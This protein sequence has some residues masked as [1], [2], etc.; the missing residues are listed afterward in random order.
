MSERFKKIYAPNLVALLIDT[1]TERDI[2]GRVLH[3]YEEEAI[4]F[5]GASDLVIRLDAL[6]DAWS[7]PQR[8]TSQRYFKDSDKEPLKAATTHLATRD[9]ARTMDE[10]YEARG[11]M[12]TFMLFVEYRQNASW[13]G[14]IIR[15]EDGCTKSFQSVL[16]LMRTVDKSL[17]AA[18]EEAQ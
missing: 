4:P 2:S 5:A 11:E 1:R 3:L 7:Y 16:E 9:K 18:G 13:Q 10:L 15:L 12:A 17:G 8:A 6:Y 14:Q